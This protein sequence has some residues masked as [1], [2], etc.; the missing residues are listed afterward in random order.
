MTLKIAVLAPMPSPSVRMKASENP[1]IRGKVRSARR[2]S[3]ITEG[4]LV[5]ALVGKTPTAGE[6]IRGVRRL[7]RRSLHRNAVPCMG[8]MGPGTGGGRAVQARV[9]PASLASFAFDAFLTFPII[10][11]ICF[12]SKAIANPV[13]SIAFWDSFAT[14][15]T[16]VRIPKGGSHDRV[17]AV[18]PDRPAVADCER[19]TVA[20]VDDGGVGG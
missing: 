17:V 15:L 8:G 1:G 13:K 11:G 4:S 2:M 6:C 5:D 9:E 14:S 19:A 16:R 10:R 3:L 7:I 18:Q 12:R 20:R